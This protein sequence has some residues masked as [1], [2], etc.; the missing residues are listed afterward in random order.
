MKFANPHIF[1]Y[2]LCVILAGIVFYMWS[3]KQYRNASTKFA[4]REILKKIDPYYDDNVL[5]LRIFLNI[6][7]IFFIGIA[8]ARPQWGTHWEEKKNTGIDI[9]IALDVSKSML[10]QDV[11]PNRIEF[12]K[13]EIRDFVKGL[14]G[15]RAG[16]IAFAGDAFLC[17]P[18]TMD[19]SGFMTSLNSEKIGSV[20]MGGT[21][22][23][24]LITEASH[25]F[26]WALSKN[27]IL[28]VV[29]DGENTEGDIRK[30]AS[31][32]KSEGI[33]IF[34]VGIGTREGVNIP[35]IDEKK[36]PGFIK[37]DSGK[38]VR[39]RL[40]EATLKLLVSETGGLYALSSREHS[41]LDLIYEKVLSKLKKKENEEVI[42]KS[43]SERFQFPL[44]LALIVL[45]FE[46]SLSV[47]KRNEDI[48]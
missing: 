46:M 34:C 48:Q 16:L 15:D 17:C 14:K 29:T 47:K 19:Y 37:D 8:L 38:V 11:S 25:D 31:F 21:S 42:A 3:A 30:A 43:Y 7:A 33:R 2:L 41:G 20:V 5:R 45:L 13:D 32:A 36:N 23:P 44:V 12:A 4:E 35:Y 26:K 6:I 40:D 10:A 18:F 28:I 1:Y 9:L 24:E 22:I 27:K 39:S